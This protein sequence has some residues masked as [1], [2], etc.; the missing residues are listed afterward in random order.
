MLRHVLFDMVLFP[1]EAERENSQKRVLCLLEALTWCDQL[2]LREH[3]ETPLIYQSGIKYKVPEQFEAEKIP[4]VGV[5][6]AYLAQKG[7]PEDVKAALEALSDRT[8]GGEHFREIPR[9][10]EN[11]GGDCD[12]VAAWRT[13]ELRELGIGAKPYITWRRR[14]DGGM[15]YHVIVRWPDG[16]S[17]DPSLLLGMGGEGRAPDRAEEERKLGERCGDFVKGAT[18]VLGEE[19]WH[20]SNSYGLVAPWGM[21]DVL[22][23]LARKLGKRRARTQVNGVAQGGLPSDFGKGLQYT[24]P[25]QTDDS[26]EAWSPTRPPAFYADPRYPGGNVQNTPFFNTRMRD[27]DEMDWDDKDDDRFDGADL[28]V[29]VH[30]LQGRRQAGAEILGGVSSHE[31]QKWERELR[32]AL[33]KL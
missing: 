9:I 23:H 2:F 25:F 10:I 7:A 31:E 21:E 30:G 28:D 18:A 6:R 17:E 15:T 27:P 24:I 20:N 8:G 22:G 26:Y 3:P 4:E 12:N 1:D 29:L 19:I 14:P 5:V 13:A 11:G 32:R 33:R 16:S